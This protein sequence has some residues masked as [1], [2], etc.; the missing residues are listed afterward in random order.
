MRLVRLAAVLA[1]SIAPLAAFAAGGHD[2]LS[3]SGCHS[4]HAAKGEIIFAV[5]A[6]KSATNRENKAVS[7]SSALCLACHKDGGMATSISSHMSHPYGMDQVNAKVAKVPGELMRGGRFECL[8]CH[9]PHPSNPYY[10]YLRVDTAKGQKMELFCGVCH[11]N[12]ADDATAAAKPALFTSMDETGNRVLAASDGSAPARK[13][14]KA[15]AKAQKLPAKKAKKG[16]ATKAA[17]VAEPVA[18]PAEPAAQ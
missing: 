6:N 14:V 9:D 3:C 5:E 12:K 2:A 16:K 15:P 8:G 17:A 10:K 1:T 7:G 4:I 11:P 18:A 13:S